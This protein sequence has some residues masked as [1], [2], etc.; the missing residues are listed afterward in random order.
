MDRSGQQMNSMREIGEGERRSL[1]KIRLKILSSCFPVL[2][3][4]QYISLPP[5]HFLS[6]CVYL[7]LSFFLNIY[8]CLLLSA[9]PPFSPHPSTSLSLSHIL[10]L[11]LPFSFSLSLFLSI[12]GFEIIPRTLQVADYVLSSEIC[13]GG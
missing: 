2:L 10:Y 4:L 1:G 7:F 12:L 5:S 9:A 3:S 6:I 11:S 13:V 8:I